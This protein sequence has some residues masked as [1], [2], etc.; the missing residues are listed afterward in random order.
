M[1]KRFRFIAVIA[2]ILCLCPLLYAQQQSLDDVCREKNLNFEQCQALKAGFSTTG[3]QITPDAVQTLMQGP[4]F[5]DL[6]PED[7]QKG[8]ELLEQK[9]KAAREKK[10]ERQVKVEPPKGIIDEQPKRESLFDRSRQ[11]GKYQEISTDLKPFGYEFFREATVRVT[12][13][14]KDIPVPLKYIIGPGDEVKILLWGRVNAQY[15]L[16]VDRDGKVTIPQIGP[17]FVAGMTFEDMSKKVITQTEQMVGANIDITLGSLKT[18]P[19]FILGDVRRPGAYTIGS[20]ATMTDALLLAGGPSDIGSMRKIQLRRKNNTIT[21]LDLYDLFMKGDKSK[22]TVLQAD[23]I[24]FVPVTG[25]LAGIAGN[26]RRPAIYELKD[27]FDLQHL[28]DLAGGILPTA[29]TQQIQVSRIQKNERQIVIDIDD[30]HL[31]KSMDFKIQDADLVNVFTIV[32]S[33]L[34]AVYLNGNVKRPGKYE[35]KPGMRVKDLIKD[36]TDLLDETNFEYALIKRIGYPDRRTE[37]VPFNLGRFLLEK[38]E[39]HN[40]SLK[41][42]DRIYI[43][44]KWF[45][46][47]KPYVTVEGEVRGQIDVAQKAKGA[48]EIKSRKEEGTPSVERTKGY[49][50]ISKRDTAEEDLKKG[51]NVISK[52]DTTEDDLKNEE[53]LSQA[54]KIKEICNELRKLE[55]PDLADKVKDIE[56]SIRKDKNADLSENA[57]Y[58]ENEMRK[59]GRYDLAD[60]MTKALNSLRKSFRIEISENMR[61]KDAVLGVGGLTKDA[62]LDRG[63]VIRRLNE[64]K[65]YQTIYFDVAKAMS[66]DPQENLLLQDRDRVIIHAVGEQFGIKSVSVDGEVTKPGSYQYTNQMRVSDLIFKAGNVL[67][68]AYLE[69]AELSSQTVENGRSV[70]LDHKKIKLQ[71][72]L[73]GNQIHNVPLKPYDRLFVM[74]IA[75]WRAEKFVSVSGEMLFQGRYIIKKGERLSSL[76]ERSGGF[77][78]KAYLRGTVFKRETVREL[79]QKGLNEMIKRLERDLLT[80]GGTMV[81]TSLSQEEVMAKKIELEQK[82]KFIASLYQLKASGRM[83]INLTHLRLLK[84]SEYDIELEDGDSLYIPPKPSVV[85]VTGAVM[86]QGSYLFSEKLDFED[87]IGMA[88]GYSRYADVDNTYILKVDGSARRVSKGFM[89]WNNNRSRWEMTAF[90]EKISELES[91][92]IIVVPE[93]IERIAWL[94]EIRDITQ[95]LMQMA[96]TAGITIKL[97]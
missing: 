87:Y 76:I 66:G 4:E 84:G 60:K 56:N 52:V 2:A 78:D 29:Y 88:G 80:E 16:T 10:M 3:G 71:E 40:I 59:M 8:K 73:R 9:E 30:K 63:E 31:S 75:N 17:I 77:T 58:V 18:I 15:N 5:K 44:S 47:D 50:T 67:E 70:R 12:T 11:T 26:V 69:E 22:D 27:R 19:I 94:R 82:Q 96:V 92:D 49:S 97:F 37:L 72:V 23:D 7:I 33:D 6:K 48:D 74:R 68:S 36:P 38:D 24:V 14:R 91:G 28:F 57:K 32:D 85:N 81:S 93:K 21:T 53:R 55:K 90:G 89:S 34:N 61:I 25:P 54:D 62:A 43:F 45:F 46:K 86:S 39:S 79:Q 41:P 42:E 1:I 35:Y 83:S 20:F 13:D 65:D 95:I 51:Y 64:G